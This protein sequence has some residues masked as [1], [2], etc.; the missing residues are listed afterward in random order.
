M[1]L[2][3]GP[4]PPAVIQ[5]STMHRK[6]TRN[7]DEKFSEEEL[8]ITELPEREEMLSLAAVLGLGGL[9]LDL[10]LGL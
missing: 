10:S 9:S 4:E 6:R 8:E 5:R 2:T 3:I 1:L 7:M